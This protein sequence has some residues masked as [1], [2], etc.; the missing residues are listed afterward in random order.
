[1]TPDSDE[2]IKADV[3]S[4]LSFSK[5]NRRKFLGTAA[6]ITGASLI[7][8]DAA[9][10]NI[11]SQNG[12]EEH[13]NSLIEQM[14]LEEKVQMMH[15]IETEDHYRYIPPIPRLG[16]PAIKMTNGPAG[17]SQGGLPPQPE[18]TALPVP[19]GLASSWDPSLAEQY[20]ALMGKET[21]AVG[22]NLLEAP[23]M[24]I[25]RVAVA[26]RNFETFGEDPYLM[27]QLVVPE[28]NG[29]QDQGIP[30][31]AKHY[32]ANNFEKR[33]RFVSVNI[34]E[35]TLREIYLPAFKN[36]VKQS[37][38]ATV[39]AAYNRVNGPYNTA[40]KHTLADILKQEWGFEGYVMSDWGATHST[41]PAVTAGLDQEMPAG[42]YFD[43][44]LITAVNSGKVSEATINDHV[45]RILGVI[46]RFDLGER[47]I[48]DADDIPIKK[49]GRIAR[50]IAEQ[51]AVLMKN[52]GSLL[53][54]DSNE[55]DS[56]AIIGPYADK[57][58]TGGG[59]TSEVVPFYTVDPLSAIR[60]RAGSDV[61]VEYVET[62]GSGYPPIPTSALI[63]PGEGD[64]QGLRAE[65]YN[66]Q[67]WE[68]EP[69]AT[70]IVK[71]INT[72]RKEISKID[73][74]GETYFSVRWT[75]KLV[76]PETGAYLFSLT[77]DDGSFLYLDGE[78]VI[79]NNGYHNSET[80]TVAVNL[81]ADRTYDIRVDW[82]QDSQDAE[83]TLAWSTPGRA[84]LSQAREAARNADV[85]LVFARGSSTE[86]SDRDNLELN[87]N[88]NELISAVASENNRTAV[89][90]RTG[91]PIVMPW[92]E[93]VPSILQMWYPGQEDGNATAS[94]LFGDT[95]PSGKLPVT[96]GKQWKD[97]PANPSEHPERYP[98]TYEGESSYPVT[99]ESDSYYLFL[100]EG[101]SYPVADYSE[102]VYV[103][104][105]YFD[106]KDIEPLFEFGH[107]ESYT[108]FEYGKLK[109]SQAAIIPEDSVTA[110]VDVSNTGGVDGAEVVQVYVSDIDPA[111]GRPPKELKG[112]SKVEIPA[113]ETQT[114]SVDLDSEAFQYWD[115]KNEDWTVNYGKFDVLVG[116]SS[117][118]IRDEVTVKV[119]DPGSG[120]D[121]GNNSADD[122][123]DDNNAGG[124]TD[125]ADDIYQG[126]GDDDNGDDIDA[127]GDGHIDEDDEDKDDD[128]DSDGNNRDDDDDGAID[129]DDDRNN[130]DD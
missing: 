113:G 19:I 4:E 16:I 76:P 93:E 109:L 56:I 95:N 70:R 33:R 15:G 71:Q 75:G 77:S 114:V 23:M 66:N 62:S 18:A 52:D 112:V 130:G 101:E 127:D 42:R 89:V 125:D 116:A 7:S 46:F 122:G 21:L 29:V 58:K 129:E 64:Q 111:V 61:S 59:G 25:V 24:N 44:D 107:G 55:V 86:G 12:S 80:K 48:A 73:G 11:N 63:P 72:T 57:A 91:G 118:D 32:V 45:R 108:S 30:A 27:S 106:E 37:N 60:E 3:E 119:H 124:E 79:G 99:D 17:V 1:M 9:S 40:N 78:Q 14:T 8:T 98:G 126:S 35:R 10:T 120:R 117:R 67:N 50:R 28:I 88:Q 2:E 110:S 100:D 97:Y 54:I 96:F 68:G 83:I 65:Y 128:D 121:N 36:A 5:I 51:G 43:E 31:D 74:L 69:V 82:F 104:Y 103:G 81:E 85:A 47:K 26:G 115:P 38:V 20:G 94:I 53:P 41:V 6:G 105:R 84:E 39:M 22:R 49:H 123:R 13:I 92:V 87:Y 102:G 90:L 34:S